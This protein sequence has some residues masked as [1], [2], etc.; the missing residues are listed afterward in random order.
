MLV[1]YLMSPI[2]K[3]NL[4]SLD[5][6]YLVT[7][8]MEGYEIGVAKITTREICDRSMSTDT[9]LPSPCLLAQLS[10]D[11]GMPEIPRDN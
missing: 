6:V 11:Q 3:D 7:V 2:N 10:L 4:L 9:T 8:I 1:H 5:S